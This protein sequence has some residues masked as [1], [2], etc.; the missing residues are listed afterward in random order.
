VNP[1]AVGLLS[2]DYPPNDGGISRLTAATAVEM[3]RR[4]ISVEVLTLAGSHFPGPERPP[5]PTREVQR[6]GLRRDLA[7]WSYVRRLP[8]ACKVL[9]SVWNPEGSIALLAGH[10]NYYLMAHG[11]EVMRYAGGPRE[12]A[13]AV[14]RKRVLSNALGVICNSRYTEALVRALA[15]QARTHVICPAVDAER[16]Q[17]P[18]LDRS[19]ARAR[20][21]LPGEKRIVLSVS[22]VNAYKGHDVV[23]RAIAGVPEHVRD[24][25]HYVVAGRGDHLAAL[26]RL[27]QELGVAGQITW[28]GFVRE[29]D[30]PALYRS[31][32]LFV[33]CTREDTL[34]RSV[35]G[36][37]MVFLEAQAA[38][39]PV[40]GTRSGGIPDAIAEG[41]GGWLVPQD[42]SEAIAAHLKRLVQ[43]P[44]E[45]AREGELGR[46]RALRDA[47]W[48][49]YVDKLLRS[50]DIQNP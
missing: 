4:G 46:A 47:S 17:L 18:E 31:A 36:F 3:A 9:A 49:G 25:L 21:G 20:L 12:T 44:A 13:K 6:T 29:E 35:E 15:P 48:S 40:L 10:R 11:N 22:R 8:A 5:L 41:Q 28:A 45:F 1:P 27:A 23:L 37:G 26:R 38:G 24:N 34:S 2:Y 43:A 42:S 16:F 50:M 33:L 39:L 30:L 19:A 7:A 32:D 14:L